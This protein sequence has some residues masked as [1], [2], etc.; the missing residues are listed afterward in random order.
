MVFERSGD[1]IYTI[2]QRSKDQIMKLRWRLDGDVLVT[3]QPSAPKEE[4][5]ALRL[6]ADR[7]LELTYGNVVAEYERAGAR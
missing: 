4:R 6:T 3:D 5:T 2:H 7:K 1:L